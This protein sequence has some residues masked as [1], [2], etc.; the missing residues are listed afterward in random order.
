[1]NQYLIIFRNLNCFFQNLFF[2]NYKNLHYK[3]Y[4]KILIFQTK[5]IFE[6]LN[7]L[8]KKVLF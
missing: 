4:K 5:F 3:N 2:D 6:L 1:M 7:I 8:F